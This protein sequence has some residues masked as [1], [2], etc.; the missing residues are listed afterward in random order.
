MERQAEEAERTV[1][2][3]KMTEFMSNKIGEVYDGI[4]SGVT[5][6]G[7]YVELE[8]TVEGYVSTERLPNG[9]YEFN[10]DQYSLTGVGETYKI[11]DKIKIRVVETDVVLR[12][13][14]FELANYHRDLDE[15]EKNNFNKNK[16]NRDE[17]DFDRKNSK[18]KNR[19]RF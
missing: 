16:N 9:R 17:R 7:F 8:N 15:E 10:E 12:H 4:I 14:D 18:R 19:R 3:Q 5:E 2:D 6:R 11:G 1:D 13:I